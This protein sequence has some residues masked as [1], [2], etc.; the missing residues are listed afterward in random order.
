M[1]KTPK[2]SSLAHFVREEVLDDESLMSPNLGNDH[3]F[4]N[5][6]CSLQ[7]YEV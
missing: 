5:K 4:I 1:T 3:R 7:W 6:E 2:E